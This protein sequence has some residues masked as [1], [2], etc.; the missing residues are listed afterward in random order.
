MKYKVGD[1]VCIRLDKVMNDEK[2]TVHDVTITRV[3]RLYAYFVHPFRRFEESRID[4][5]GT[6]MSN[7]SEYIQGEVVR[8]REDYLSMIEITNKASC[9]GRVLNGY[10]YITFDKVRAMTIEERTALCSDIDKMI[11]I[12]SKEKQ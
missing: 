11:N 1:M 9:L 5:D 10:W 7:K 6:V 12:F 4:K 3:G 8:S 2:E